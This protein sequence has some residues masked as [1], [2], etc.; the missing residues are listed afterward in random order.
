M[1]GWRALEVAVLDGDRAQHVVP[2]RAPADTERITAARQVALDALAAYE[3]AGTRLVVLGFDASVRS[4]ETVR[5]AVADH[6]GGAR[7]PLDQDAA[8]AVETAYTALVS[9]VRDDGRALIGVAD[10]PQQDPPE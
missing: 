6:L 10:G 7:P 9:A 8:R 4:W 1:V 5:A 3:A 2:G